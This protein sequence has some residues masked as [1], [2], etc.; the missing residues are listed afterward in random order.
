MCIKEPAL[1]KIS[2]TEIRNLK[3]KYDKTK[4]HFPIFVEAFKERKLC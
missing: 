4:L 1:N 2:N 3:K